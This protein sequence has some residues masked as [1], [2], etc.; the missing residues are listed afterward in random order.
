MAPSIG[1]VGIV[2]VI[3]ALGGIAIIGYVDPLVAAGVVGILLGL[4]LIIQD[5]L[6]R[7][8]S[9]MGLTGAF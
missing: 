3:V 2:G 5:L 6:R 4:G 8:L 7:V 9:S 1:P